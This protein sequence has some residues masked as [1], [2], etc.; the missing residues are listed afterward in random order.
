MKNGRQKK[1]SN[2]IDILIQP[3]K[4][5]QNTPTTS[6]CR[7]KTEQGQADEGYQLY[8]Q[9]RYLYGKVNRYVRPL[10]LRRHG[11]LCTIGYPSSC[12]RDSGVHVADFVNHVPVQL[13]NIMRSTLLASLLLRRS[14]MRWGSAEKFRT[15]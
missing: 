6:K 9:S 1:K 5:Q 7:E 10:L 4:Q 15:V 13:K 11:F 2:D 14:S 8:D 12:L 3:L